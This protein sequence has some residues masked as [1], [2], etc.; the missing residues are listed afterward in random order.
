MKDMQ[1][2]VYGA[3][4]EIACTDSMDR[5]NRVI[6]HHLWLCKR[7]EEMGHKRLEEAT[8]EGVVRAIFRA[9]NRKVK[10]DLSS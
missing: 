1:Y 4:R 8:A 7:D 2:I 9:A 5:V 10:P 3:G 6:D